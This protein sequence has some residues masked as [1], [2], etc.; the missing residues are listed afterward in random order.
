MKQRIVTFL[1]L[2]LYCS[3]AHCPLPTTLPPPM[4][5]PIQNS[6]YIRLF[7]SFGRASS[8]TSSPV[9]AVTKPNPRPCLEDFPF[10]YDYHAWIV[11]IIDK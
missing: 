11:L 2:F 10:H 1:K 3:H 5:C 4:H 6:T 9:H 7:L 8:M